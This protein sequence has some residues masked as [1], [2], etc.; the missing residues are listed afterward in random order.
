M[1]SELFHTTHK[2]GLSLWLAGINQHHRFN[3][4]PYCGNPLVAAVYFLPR[5]HEALC[6][7]I[8]VAGEITLLMAYTCERCA[9][10]LF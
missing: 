10:K 2:K 9:M 6:V 7:A 3:Y 8:F 1:P 5:A 4:I